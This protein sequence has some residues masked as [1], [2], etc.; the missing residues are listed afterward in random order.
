MV[1]TGAKIDSFRSAIW[2]RSAIL[3][4]PSIHYLVLGH[5]TEPIIILSSLAS[6]YQIFILKTTIVS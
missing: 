3:I 6:K 2:F 1:L 5:Q 4:F